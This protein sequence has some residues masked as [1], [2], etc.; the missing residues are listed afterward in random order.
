MS[1]YSDSEDDLSTPEQKQNKELEAEQNDLIQFA[2]RNNLIKQAAEGNKV[3]GNIGPF[4]S[5]GNDDYRVIVNRHGHGI[6]V[7]RV[8]AT[9]VNIVIIELVPGFFEKR[10]NQLT[11][12]IGRN[13]ARDLRSEEVAAAKERKYYHAERI[14]RAKLIVALPSDVILQSEI[15]FSFFPDSNPAHFYVQPSSTPVEKEKSETIDYGY[16]K[17]EGI[18]VKHK[19]LSLARKIMTQYARLHRQSHARLHRQSHASLHRQSQRNHLY[20]GAR[21]RT[22]CVSRKQR[23]QRKQCKSRKQRK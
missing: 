4:Y 9:I 12:L 14:P 19:I 21:K 5:G 20:G 16:F 23:K 8:L 17:D 13:A 11:Q 10:Y 1:S 6:G 2:I 15:D 3:T 18:D 7:G 22:T